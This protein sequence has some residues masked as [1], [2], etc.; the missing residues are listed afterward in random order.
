M[1]PNFSKI[2]VISFTRK[3]SVLNFQYRLVN[4]FILRTDCIKDLGAYIDCKLYFHQ[5][6]NFIFSHAMKLLVLGLIRT[7]TFSFSTLDSLLILFF[8]WLDLKWSMFL[9]LGTLLQLLTP[10]NLFACKENFLPFA[11]KHFFK[12]WNTIIL[13]LQTLYIRRRHFDALFLINAFCGT[14]YCPSV[15][16]TVGLR[17]PTRNIILPRPVTPSATA[18]RQDIYLLQM[19]FV[20]Q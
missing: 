12:M 10:I 20:N 8:L 17:V 16:E 18:L 4:Y 3:T 13:N 14:K 19:Q 5:H 6:L 15:L 7:L 2:R 9:L 1:K 11:T